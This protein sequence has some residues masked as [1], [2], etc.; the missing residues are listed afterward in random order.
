MTK[1]NT[2]VQKNRQ[3]SKKMDNLLGQFTGNPEKEFHI[4]KL[5]KME[6]TSPSTVS[7]YLKYLEK[8][9]ILKVRKLSNHL[10]YQANEG[11][12]GFRRLKRRM[13]REAIEQSGILESLQREFNEPEA[14]IL[15]GS[16]AKGEDRPQS[17]IDIALITATKKD[18]ALSVLEKKLGRKLHLFQFSRKDIDDMKAGNRELLN[19]LVNGDILSGYWE[20]FR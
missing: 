5:A 2:I 6:K 7:K 4:R 9:G 18:I 15:F 16:A 19:T 17:D 11:S 14:M 20:L 12:D 10:F 8:Q 3:L 1:G 13:V